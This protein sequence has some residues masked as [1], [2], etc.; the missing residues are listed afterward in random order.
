MLA[1]K[2]GYTIFVQP[3]VGKIQAVAFMI[4]WNVHTENLNWFTF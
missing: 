1:G 2:E 3:V 4:Y